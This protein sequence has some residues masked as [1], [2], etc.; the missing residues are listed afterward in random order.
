MT[1]DGAQ[2]TQT[3][4]AY[5][6]WHSLP[7]DTREQRLAAADAPTR[8]AVDLVMEEALAGTLPV[9]L[10]DALLTD[11]LGDAGYRCS[12]GGGLVED[13]LTWHLPRYGEAIAVRARAEPVWIEAL[14]CVWLD[15]PLWEQPPGDAQHWVKEPPKS[16]E[17]RPVSEQP[18]R[19]GRRRSRSG[20][21]QR[22]RQG[23]R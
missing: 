15:R 19:P 8:W 20:S 1:W 17:Q 18:R 9:E 4:D 11:P 5:R 14:A 7:Q 22:R 13:V 23:P 21:D 3:A 2:I 16:G 12:V 10:L 6:R